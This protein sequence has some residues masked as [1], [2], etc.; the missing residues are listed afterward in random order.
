[1][2]AMVVH[3]CRGNIGTLFRNLVRGSIWLTEAFN[4]L[5]PGVT[6]LKVF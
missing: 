6:F 1:M 5:K 4:P 3:K 2:V